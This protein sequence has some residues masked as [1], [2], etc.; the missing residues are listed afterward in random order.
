MLEKGTMKLKDNMK[1]AFD[2]FMMI[3]IYFWSLCKQYVYFFV[4]SL[5]ITKT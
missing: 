4:R 3:K 1:D 5:R 2:V